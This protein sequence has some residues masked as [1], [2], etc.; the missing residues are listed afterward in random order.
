MLNLNAINALKVSALRAVIAAHFAQKIASK[1]DLLETVST[2][3][4]EPIQ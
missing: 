3:L 2:A 4:K 1:I